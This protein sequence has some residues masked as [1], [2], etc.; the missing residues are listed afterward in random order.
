MLRQ[1]G[2]GA[3][4]EAGVVRSVREGE[5]IVGELVSLKPTE[6]NPRLCDVEVHVDRRP[7]SPDHKGPRRVASDAY[8]DGWD[9]IFGDKRALN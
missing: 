6:E 1:R 2:E 7:M 5:P 4:V 3:P 9:A 8:R